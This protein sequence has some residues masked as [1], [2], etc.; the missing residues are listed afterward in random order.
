MA[1]HV[2]AAGQRCFFRHKTESWVLGHGLAL[3]SIYVSL[4]TLGGAQC[5]VSAALEAGMLKKMSPLPV[6]PRGESFFS[7]WES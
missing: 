5:R 4:Q 6:S 1:A 2:F 7:L 3:A